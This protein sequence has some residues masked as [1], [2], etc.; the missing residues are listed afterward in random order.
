MWASASVFSLILACMSQ[1]P[2]R[3]AWEVVR[4]AD[5]D[6]AFSMPVKTEPKSA[7]AAGASGAGEVI[8]YFCEVQGTTY[9]IRRKRLDQP[10][11]S[12]QVIAEL[13]MMKKNYLEQNSRLV[14]ETKLVVDGVPGDDLTY[15]VPA[16]KDNATVTR[17]IRYLLKDRHVYELTVT[18]PP[19]QPLPADATRFLSSLTFEA[20][21]K[22][23]MVRMATNAKPAARPRGEPRRIAPRTRPAEPTPR[24]RVDLADSTPEEALM[25]FLLALAAQD[26]ATLRAVT[27]PDEDFDWLLKGHPVPATP[28]VL[29][30][31]KSSFAKSS[32]RR[33]GV[34]D[35]VNLPG[36]RVGV[37]KPADVADGRVV[38]L[39][40]NPP[41]P[42][43]LE[44]VGGHW[45][46]FARTVIAARKSADSARQKTHSQ[47][48]P[49][50]RRPER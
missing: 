31:L 28:Q 18:S 47:P 11:A 41:L 45:R 3:P 15:T 6:F 35:R 36:G 40:V 19:G 30:T 46:V 32:F 10:V 12:G 4:S 9:A 43:R 17:R 38:L 29:A 7:G 49:R 39:P 20:L 37:I 33:L 2:G 1:A 25:T 27:L 42:A 26:E 34:G 23:N 44:N 8:E 5:G 22:A 21:L 24:T 50:P 13:A 16:S 48:L 14:K